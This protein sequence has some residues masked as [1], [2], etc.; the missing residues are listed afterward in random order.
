MSVDDDYGTLSRDPFG[1]VIPENVYIRVLMILIMESVSRKKTLHSISSLSSVHKAQIEKERRIFHVFSG[2]SILRNAGQKADK[3]RKG[4]PVLT[5]HACIVRPH[6]W[7]RGAEST[8]DPAG[9]KKQRSVLA[10]LESGRGF[11]QR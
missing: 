8:C 1:I 4:A 3:R 5:H 7:I 9:N 10:L 6:Y 2:R 11:V